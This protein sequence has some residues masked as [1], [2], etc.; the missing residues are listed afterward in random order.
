[1]KGVKRE[2]GKKRWEREMEGRK[3]EGR[4]EGGQNLPHFHI[5]EANPSVRISRGVTFKMAEG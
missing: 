4:E 2:E 5:S 1:M 3:C